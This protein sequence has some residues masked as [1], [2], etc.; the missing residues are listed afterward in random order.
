MYYLSESETELKYFCSSSDCGR[1]SD[2][3]GKCPF[4]EVSVRRSVRSEKCPFG[5]VSVRRSVR[6]GKCPFGEVSGRGSVR[7][8]KCL[9]LH[10][11]AYSFKSTYR[12][13]LV[14]P[15]FKISY[16]GHLTWHSTLQDPPG[17]TILF[18]PGYFRLLVSA[19]W[20]NMN[21]LHHIL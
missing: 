5:E 20:F 21:I 15:S 13:Q 18:H 3:S 4:G 9:C 7:S 2:R 6:S 8:G 1:R 19:N 17:Y 14:D 12:K 10:L 11:S 16:K